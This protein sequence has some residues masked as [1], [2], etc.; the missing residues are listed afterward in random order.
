M[1]ETG[2]ARNSTT[3]CSCP[4]GLSFMDCPLFLARRGDSPRR[5]VPWSKPLHLAEVLGSFGRR[6][7]SVN[8][9][10]ATPSDTSVRGSGSK[11]YSI[12]ITATDGHTQVSISL[13]APPARFIAV[14][15]SKTPEAEHRESVDAPR[16][17]AQHCCAVRLPDLLH[18]RP[19]DEFPTQ[20]V[21]VVRIHLP[22]CRGVVHVR[23]D[24]LGFTSDSYH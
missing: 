9:T 16:T 2:L 1:H 24:R 5:T 8:V 17:I 10:P 3:R 21:S 15:A 14:S 22:S 13:E 6:R 12:S 23:N 4:R 7:R 11:Q 19:R 20:S 18:L